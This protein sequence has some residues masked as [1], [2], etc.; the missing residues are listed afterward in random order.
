MIDSLAI[1]SFVFASLDYA[2][3]HGL[4]SALV[5]VATHLWC[6]SPSSPVSQRATLWFAALCACALAP[7]SGLPVAMTTVAPPIE[8][9]P[10]V[11]ADP[12]EGGLALDVT[13]ARILFA[14]WWVGVLLALMRLVLAHRRL[15]RELAAASRSPAL[16]AMYRNLLPEGVE[17]R[18]SGAI[19]PLVAGLRRPVIV[20][21][22][23][24]VD[25]LSADALRAVLVHEATH[26]RRRDPL[27]QTLQRLIEAVFWWNPLIRVAGARLDAAREVACDAQAASAFDSGADYA[28]SLLDAVAQIIPAGAQRSL[29]VLGMHASTAL[30]HERITHLIEPRPAAR[31]ILRCAL[32]V[33]LLALAGAGWMAALAAPRLIPTHPDALSETAQATSQAGPSQQGREQVNP[34]RANAAQENTAQDSQVYEMQLQQMSE[35]YES[36]LTQANERHQH[37]LTAANERFESELALA[38]ERYARE[39][40]AVERRTASERDAVERRI[41]SERNTSESP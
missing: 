34:A 29:A 38:N 20:L 16:E 22:A 13:L 40:D 19:G 9:L 4:I 1:D 32:A 2:L 7:L 3:A 23:S 6:R 8:T 14:A 30:L 17:V 21:P 25:A 18:L 11:V 15:R 37:D 41:A 31:P 24:L 36:A 5:L 33:T 10:V 35:A 26:V 39:R 27:T 28:E 12:G